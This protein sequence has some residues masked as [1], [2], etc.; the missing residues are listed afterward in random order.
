MV[1]N[2]GNADHTEEELRK[3]LSGKYEGILEIPLCCDSYDYKYG[4][5]CI[6]VTK[7]TI[8]FIYS[9]VIY[10]STNYYYEDKKILVKHN[11]YSG[12]PLVGWFEKKNGNWLFWQSFDGY[13]DDGLSDKKPD[14]I[15]KK[16]NIEDCNSE[17]TSYINQETA[18]NEYWVTFK[19]AIL[20]KDINLL[21][22]LVSLP[23]KDETSWSDE[24]KLSKEIRSGNELY[25]RMEIYLAKVET[26]PEEYFVD[27]KC[28]KEME[29][30]DFNGGNYIFYGIFNLVFD[31]INGE[32]KLVKLGSWG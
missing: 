8:T 19:N 24:H 21:S 1:F 11:A 27:K 4:T 10:D 13:E 31:K 17:I 29:S 7:T 18:F 22:N 26:N 12:N 6:D 25:Q 15:T 9:G 16:V 20:N 2:S 3:E 28:F 32:Y 5:V 23:L 14:F 30:N